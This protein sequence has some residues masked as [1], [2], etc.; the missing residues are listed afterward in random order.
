MTGAPPSAVDEVRAVCDQ[1]AETLAGGELAVEVD[2]VRAR[3][4][5]PLRVAIAGRVKAGKSTMLNA[6][7]GERVAPTDAGE[8]TRVVTWYQEGLGYEVQAVLRGG[9]AAPLPFERANGALVLDLDGH[10]PADVERI[11]VRWPSSALRAVTLIDTPGLASL[12]DENSLRTREFLAFGDDRPSDADA[13]IYLVRHLHRRDTEF[14]SAF[15]DRSV[16]AASPVNAVVVLS[17]ADE[18]G[19]GRLDAME[20]SSRIAERYATDPDLS[21]LSSAVVPVVGLLAETGQTFREDEMA[22]LRTLSGTDPEELAR[23]LLSVTTFTE[24]GSSDLTVELRRDLLDRLGIFGVR[25]AVAQLQVDP[26]MSA[27]AMA[28]S[29]VAL[30]GLDALRALIDGHFLPR[31]QV[32]KARSA[33]TSLRSIASRLA[34]LDPAAASTLAAAVER[35]EASTLDFAHLRLSHLARVGEVRFGEE[36][37]LEVERLRT[38]GPVAERLGLPAETGVDALRDEVVRRLERWRHRGADPMAGSALFEASETMARTYEAVFV[39]V[40]A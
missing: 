27:G 37:L 16:T 5:G 23:M 39:E 9:A 2:A 34:L 3:I 19:A 36:E 33:L 26:S 20:S 18:I 15:M 17:R 13:V 6:L 7:V 22:A 4:D 30:S 38:P 32:L 29:L 12:D 28:A 21:R 40:G 24:P 14:L 1:F 8:C 25:H 35:C 31:A 11:D 10:A